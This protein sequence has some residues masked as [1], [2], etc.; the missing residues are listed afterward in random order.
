MS[1][2][3]KNGIL[4]GA[5]VI[6]VIAA[7]FFFTRAKK[8]GD[9]PTDTGLTHWI[10][11]KC[12]NHIELSPAKYQDWFKDPARR[13]TDPNFTTKM[14]VFWCESCQ[15]FTVVRADKDRKTGE[16]INRLDSSGRPV[17]TAS[18]PKDAEKEKKPE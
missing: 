14:P 8:E 15:A 12:R 6:I 17:Q 11:E 9:F 3:V 10:C 2:A 4:L 13:R 18:P 1:P 16:W 7:G 5:L